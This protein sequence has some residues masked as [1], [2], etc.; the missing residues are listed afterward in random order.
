[1]GLGAFSR[2]VRRLSWIL[3]TCWRLIMAVP[4]V[5]TPCKAVS[6]FRLAVSASAPASNAFWC[7]SLA[8]LSTTNTPS[9]V[10]WRSSLTCVKRLSV[11]LSRL[12][13]SALFCVIWS[14]WS[15][16]ILVICWS[17]QTVFAASAWLIVPAKTMPITKIAVKFLFIDFI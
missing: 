15:F 3:S 11:A 7:A 1:M 14:W 8:I 10:D 9:F 6:L 17:S 5:A 13:L 12:I 4:L 16:T 2:A